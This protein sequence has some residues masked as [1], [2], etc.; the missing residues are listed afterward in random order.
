M[1]GEGEKE[2]GGKVNGR[3]PDRGWDCLGRRATNRLDLGDATWH[4]WHRGSSATNPLK[5]PTALYSLSCVV[6]IL[7]S[8]CR[9][10]FSTLL[11]FPQNFVLTKMTPLFCLRP[12]VSCF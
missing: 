5:F 10:D 11:P 2:G 3:N 9:M 8:I 7:I 4:G 6:G 12:N 1:G